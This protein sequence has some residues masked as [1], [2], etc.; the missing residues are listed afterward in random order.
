MKYYN[1][2]LIFFVSIKGI[3]GISI[4]KYFLLLDHEVELHILV[5]EQDINLLSR[6]HVGK[7]WTK[8]KEKCLELV[9]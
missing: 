8:H 5:P 4:L 1:E 3:V 2:D 7:N 9:F 6:I